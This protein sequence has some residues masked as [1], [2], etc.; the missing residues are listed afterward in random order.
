MDALE[1]Q[2]LAGL[3]YLE[4]S[5]GVVASISRWDWIL[6]SVSNANYNKTASGLPWGVENALPRGLGWR[7]ASAFSEPSEPSLESGFSP[8]LV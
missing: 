2:L 8:M 5:P 6:N 3:C 1:D 4:Q 7:Y